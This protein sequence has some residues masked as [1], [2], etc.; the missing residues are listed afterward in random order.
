MLSGAIL[1][2]VGVVLIAVQFQHDLNIPN[3]TPSPRILETSPTGGLKLSTTYVGL[4]VVGIGA[5]LEIAG[6]VAATPWRKPTPHSK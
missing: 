2:A 1:I 6:Y 5:A 3:F 4:I